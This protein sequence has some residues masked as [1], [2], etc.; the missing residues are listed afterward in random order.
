MTKFI[1]TVRSVS[2][3]AFGGDLGR[4]RYLAVPDDDEPSPSNEIGFKA[5]AKQVISTFG[6]T[7]EGN[8]LLYVHGFNETIADVVGTHTL[9]ATGLA[10]NNFTCTMIS[11]DW[12]SEGTAFAYLEDASQA[13][14]SAVDLVNSCVKP[15]LASQPESCRVSVH[16]VCHSMGAYVVRE[17]LDHADD[18]AKT[19]TNW[20]LNQ[21]VMVAGDVEAEDFVDGNKNTDSMLL[22][23]YRLTNYFNLYDEVLQVSNAKRL[24]VAP[25]VGRIGLPPNAPQKTVN[26]DC[27][28]RF[29]AIGGTTA[30]T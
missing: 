28:K 30:S 19:A 6:P 22:H 16:V 26:I 4:V 13:K 7:A 12:P 27:S 8:L 5:W 23:C 24:G 1:V 18:G 14:I 29:E 3:D 21:L 10:S 2:G 15:L 25:R 11:F 20:T 9:M 17:G